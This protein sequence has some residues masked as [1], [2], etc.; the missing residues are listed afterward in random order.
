MLEL[1]F[2]RLE[3]CVR[4]AVNQGRH[5]SFCLCRVTWDFQREVTV[6]ADLIEIHGGIRLL[7]PAAAH[8]V[9]GD[10]VGRVSFRTFPANPFAEIVIGVSDLV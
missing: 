8:I 5:V 4:K 10:A 3:G 6:G 9:H 7:L 2:Q 1:C